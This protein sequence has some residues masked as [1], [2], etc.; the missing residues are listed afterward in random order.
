MWHHWVIC[1]W[2]CVWMLLSGTLFTQSRADSITHNRGR[3]LKTGTLKI[4]ILFIN[5]SRD[6]AALGSG[7][8]QR[9]NSYRIYRPPSLHIQSTFLCPWHFWP[10][11]S[12][13]CIR[14]AEEHPRQYA[15]PHSLRLLP[16]PSAPLFLFKQNLPFP[17]TQGCCDGCSAQGQELT[18]FLPP[19]PRSRAKL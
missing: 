8:G 3:N 17:K 18:L 7:Q 15:A 6:G 10:K 16:T 11:Q 19:L 14:I 5:G 12:S 4:K 9:M 2:K 13:K 1:V